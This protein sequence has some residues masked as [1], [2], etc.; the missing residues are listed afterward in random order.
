MSFL[1][2]LWIRDLGAA[3]RSIDYVSRNLRIIGMASNAPEDST[4]T[5][6]LTAF[7]QHRQRC[8][9]D[10][11]Y[12]CGKELVIDRKGGGAP[13]PFVFNRAQEYVWERL[14]EQ[15]ESNGMIR[16]NILKGRQ[17]FVAT[18]VFK[19]LG[20]S[21]FVPTKRFQQFLLVVP[22]YVRCLHCFHRSI[23]SIVPI[24]L[25]VHI[26]IHTVGSTLIYILAV[27][28]TDFIALPIAVPSLFL[29]PPL[30]ALPQP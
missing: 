25:V 24:V 6:Y 19:I 5:K 28:F 9:Y 26:L 13:V 23:S 10:F 15:W 17:Q 1:I 29:S 14:R 22:F 12:F 20:T 11:P 4:T 2:L 30:V 8:S 7:A 27:N 18:E 21:S 3:L 16:A